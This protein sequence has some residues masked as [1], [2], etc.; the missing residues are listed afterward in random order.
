ML[1][2]LLGASVWLMIAAAFFWMTTGPT[3]SGETGVDRNVFRAMAAICVVAG[4]VRFSQA[5]S[6]GFEDMFVFVP[7]LLA[8]LLVSSCLVGL[9]IRLR[10]QKT[11]TE[12]VPEQ[13]YV[14]AF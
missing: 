6:V 2:L 13:P 12:E 7:M 10:G 4:I 9:T 5:F 11:N 14:G 8:F 1:F 3:Q